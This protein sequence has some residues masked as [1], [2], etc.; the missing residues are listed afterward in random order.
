M[1][2]LIVIFLFV[3]INLKAT[4]YYVSNSG[5]DSNSGI[6]TILPWK[7][8]NNVNTNTFLQ[9][10]SIL[11]KRGDVWIEALT[12][13]NYILSG[14][15]TG[16]KPEI[17]GYD[18]ITGWT[19]LGNWSEYSTG[20]WRWATTESN[21]L[22]VNGR[23]RK[24]SASLTLTDEYFWIWTGGYLYIKAPSNPATY[25]HSIMNG[26]KLNADC[27]YMLGATNAKIIN[28]KISGSVGIVRSSNVEIYNCEIGYRTDFYGLTLMGSANIGCTNIL[29]HG[30]VVD[31]GDSLKYNYYR[32]ANGSTNNGIWLNRGSSNCKVYN[33]YIRNWSHSGIAMFN[34]D[35]VSYTMHDNEI[36]NNF[37]TAPLIDYGRG[38]G[39]D[40]QEANGYN[41]SFHDNTIVN[42]SVQNQI[43][44]NGL[45]F[46]NNII[47]NVVGCTYPD[48]ANVGVGISIS[49]Y[50]PNS[51]PVNMEIYNNL[52]RNCADPA[53][54][55]WNFD[56]ATQVSHINIHD[57]NFVNCN[58]AFGQYSLFVRYN[59]PIINHN[60]YSNN[61]I[62][63]SFNT[64]TVKYNNVQMNVSA[65]NGI[66]P[67]YNDVISG[68]DA[69]LKFGGYPTTVDDLQIIYNETNTSKT[70]SLSQPMINTAGDKY[71]SSVTLQPYTSMVL[72]KDKNILIKYLTGEDGKSLFIG[73][74]LMMR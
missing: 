20:V 70:F 4:N 71:T 52:I 33:N 57:N 63:N 62:Y 29:I 42:T 53:I 55:V 18:E 48:K 38:F 17:R 3:S 13:G 7:T 40:Y 11:L 68:N 23:E 14:Y 27:I 43:S 59:Q 44:A 32:G 67:N 37:I 61:H 69:I 74:K 15:G 28:V 54:W 9:G 46:Y 30:N 60:S 26:L 31:T 19:T 34:D 64:N 5:N 6:T 45:K 35:N 41:N 1:K 16:S 24:E 56:A 58:Q 2:Y 65:F 51:P 10:D 36:Y 21:R 22:W 73:N 8:L 72:M 47:D 66:S 25:F 12:Q 39:A 49:S 50:N